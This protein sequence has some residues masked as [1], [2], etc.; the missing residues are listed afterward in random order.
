VTAT[1]IVVFPIGNVM[2]PDAVPLMTEVP[3]TVIVVPLAAVGVTVM[4]VVL[5]YVTS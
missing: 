4:L 3:L 2:E 1:V 5:V